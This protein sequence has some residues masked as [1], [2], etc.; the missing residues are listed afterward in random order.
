MDSFKIGGIAM[1]ISE[2]GLHLIEEFEGF[3][4]YMYDDATG[5]RIT[6]PSQ[7][8]G[9]ATIGFGTTLGAGVVNPLPE[10]CTEAEAEGWLKLY[11]ERQVEPAIDATGAK[12]N[13]NQ[14][15]ALCSLGYN[16][17]AGC[18]V[19]YQIGHDLRAGN[20]T[21][22][23][24][25]FMQYVEANG[26]VL[27]GLVTRRTAERKLFD[28]PWVAPPPPDPNHYLWFDDTKTALGPGREGTE[29]G[30]ARQYDTERRTPQQHPDRLKVLQSDCD[31]FA[32]RLEAMSRNG[33]N[34]DQ[35][36]RAWRLT[37]LAER[38]EGQ[39]VVK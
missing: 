20:L 38:G 9:T 15:D 28:T 37:Q 18:F 2:T 5:A 34:M 8:R 39:L 29:Q 26:G 6:S 24:A 17:G 14:F 25:D 32:K 3:R 19:S 31:F 21:A 1:N 33:A 36:H 35:F 10:T 27:Q 11:V 23:S 13:Q 22:A 16:L 30:V 12:L 7:A 4:S